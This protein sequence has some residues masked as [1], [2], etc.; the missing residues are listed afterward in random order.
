MRAIA[1]VI[2][3]VGG[4]GILGVA[5]YGLLAT[6]GSG[7]YSWFGA[8][9]GTLCLLGGGLVNGYPRLA[10]T[11]LLLTGLVLSWPPSGPTLTL[12]FP[13]LLAAIL[14]LASRESPSSPQ[15]RRQ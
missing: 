15:P 14:T 1:R 13:F 3:L 5:I 8:I 9:L 6:Q 10:A 4:L 11:L 12:A 2:G 7:S